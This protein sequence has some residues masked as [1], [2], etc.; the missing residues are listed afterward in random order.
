MHDVF[1]VGV[2]S[3]LEKHDADIIIG[4]TDS[5]MSFVA[6]LTGESMDASG[7]SMTF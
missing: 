1:K 4:P 5:F 2:D 3:V 6:T 7:R